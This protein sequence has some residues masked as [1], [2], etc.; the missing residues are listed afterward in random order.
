ML[1]LS[2]GVALVRTLHLCFI[3]H[4]SLTIVSQLVVVG[5]ILRRYLHWALALDAESGL[6]AL[7]CIQESL[8]PQPRV[9]CRDMVLMHAT[10]WSM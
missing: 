7:Q 5:L 8:T 3:I 1:L 6:T 2:C 9:W 10:T 4:V